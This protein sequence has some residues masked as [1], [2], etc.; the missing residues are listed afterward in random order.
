MRVEEESIHFHFKLGG[1]VPPTVTGNR[2]YSIQN[3]IKQ[4]PGFGR[5]ERPMVTRERGLPDE[6]A[7][8]LR[9]GE[10]GGRQYQNFSSFF[11]SF[12]GRDKAKNCKGDKK[13]EVWGSSEHMG[14]Q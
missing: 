8:V 13:I 1:I 2:I 4:R 9:M 11:C 7:T 14:E 6:V 12:N 10:E 3:G 5:D